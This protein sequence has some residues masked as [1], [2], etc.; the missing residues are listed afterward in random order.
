MYRDKILIAFADAVMSVER[1]ST[2]P[3]PH[4]ITAVIP[5]AEIR[6]KIYKNGQLIEETE[7]ILNS[8]TIA[9]SPQHPPEKTADFIPDPK[10]CSSAVWRVRLHK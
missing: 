7:T 1:Y 6:R 2:L 9:H 3:T 5:R 4:E 8:V 10:P